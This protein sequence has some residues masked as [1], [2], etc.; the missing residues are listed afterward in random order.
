MISDDDKLYLIL[1][2]D[3][4]HVEQFCNEYFDYAGLFYVDRKDG[5]YTS[6]VDR[7]GS[8]NLVTSA[9]G[10]P[11]CGIYIRKYDKS[12]FIKMSRVEDEMYMINSLFY[13]IRLNDDVDLSDK[14][15]INIEMLGSFDASSG[16]LF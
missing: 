4:Q 5:I 2:D 14:T 7:V 13:Y 10:E 1:K 16:D 9:D 15:H 6:I 3:L 11:V 8:E 12:F